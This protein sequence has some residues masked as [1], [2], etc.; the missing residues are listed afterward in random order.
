MAKGAEVT[1]K[2]VCVPLP[3]ALLAAEPEDTFPFSEV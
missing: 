3:V 1:G 2:M